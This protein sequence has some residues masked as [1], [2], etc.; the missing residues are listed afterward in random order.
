M[1]KIPY[2]HRE[3]RYFTEEKYKGNYESI[4]KQYFPGG[5]YYKVRRYT[6]DDPVTKPLQDAHIDY[7]VLWRG[8]LYLIDFKGVNTKDG[9][10][11]C[12]ILEIFRQYKYLQPDGTYK[13]GRII[14]GWV[15]SCGEVVV[16]T[17]IL[18]DMP[19]AMRDAIPDGIIDVPANR[20]YIIRVSEKEFIRF[21]KDEIRAYKFKYLERFRLNELVCEIDS[22]NKEESL[23]I[24]HD[25]NMYFYYNDIKDVNY[26]EEIGAK[27]YHLCR[28]K[29]YQVP[30]E[31]LGNHED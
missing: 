23:I 11:D 21:R 8:K 19:K 29:W 6:E 3:V 28:G 20:Q 4:I 14:E 26:L 2:D 24:K 18:D 22:G 31:K 9:Y 17:E 25:F 7:I 30:I 15:K 16:P 12:A 13:S 1:F 5:T 10:A 27:K